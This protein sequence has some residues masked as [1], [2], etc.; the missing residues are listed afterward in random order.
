M[1]VT[2]ASQKQPFHSPKLVQYG[3]VRELTRAV[4]NN[5]KILDGGEKSDTKTF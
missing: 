4:S 5:S 1:S 2:S 3:D